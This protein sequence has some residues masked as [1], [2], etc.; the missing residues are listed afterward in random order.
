MTY[1]DL[2][3]QA[4][5]AL[6]AVVASMPQE[7][8]AL[9]AYIGAL[10]KKSIVALG[11][12]E[13]FAL[14]DKA[15]EIKAFKQ[16][17]TL[18]AENGGLVKPGFSDKIPFVVSAQG[19]EMWAEAAGA[20][21][22]FPKSVT[23]DGVEQTNPHVIRDPNNRRILNIYARAVA[24]RFSS[25]GLPMVADWTTAYD[26]P[27]Y[28]LIDLVAK[29][30]Q[31]PQA[32][33][34]LPADMEKPKEEGTWGAY[35]F[36]ETMVLW[37]NSKHGEALKW[38]GEILN[39]EKKAID[40]AQTF[41]RRN[42]CKHLSGLQKA[43]GPR[44]D[45]SIICWRPTGDSI[46]KWDNTQYAN[47]QRRIEGLGEGQNFAALTEGEKPMA[48]QYTTGVD[49]MDEEEG[50]I[51]AEDEEREPGE[52]QAEAAAPLDMTPGENGTYGHE[53][54]TPPAAPT[55][56]PET[57]QANFA[58]SDEDKKALANYEEVRANF[59]DEDR[60][61]RLRMSIKPDAAVT[62]KQARELYKTIGSMVDGAAQ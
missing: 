43:P 12:D 7:G 4:Q 40:F 5:A 6:G 20:C 47:V 54:E 55:D 39:R 21:V 17:L 58:H 49:H 11:E 45:L 30:K 13:A 1:A 62:P 19:Y 46:M 28:R 36:D 35:P 29:A 23:V 53:N 34:L 38:Y 60:K 14:T 8:K 57:A 26:V 27:S 52:A 31:T 15:G 42:A 16:R 33:K 61:A 44:W 50:L 10:H 48:V 59:P 25:K 24:F 3:T 32:F 22:I 41:A 18:S 9:S 56:E 37:V 2:Q 51:N